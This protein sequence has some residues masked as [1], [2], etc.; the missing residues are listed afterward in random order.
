M[1]DRPDFSLFS[2]LKCLPKE[3][4]A[5]LPISKSCSCVVLEKGEETNF[6]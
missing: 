4:T 3:S 1:R 5:L 2:S 6:L